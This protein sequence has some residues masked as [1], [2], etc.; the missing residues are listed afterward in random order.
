MDVEVEM[1]IM[2]LALMLVSVFGLGTS[3]GGKVAVVVKKGRGGK[4]GE[5]R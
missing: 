1:D 2:L 5:G 3:D 4:K